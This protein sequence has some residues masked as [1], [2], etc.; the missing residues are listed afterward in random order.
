M[1]KV[2][3]RLAHVVILTPICDISSKLEKSGN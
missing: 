1:Q 3:W 2:S